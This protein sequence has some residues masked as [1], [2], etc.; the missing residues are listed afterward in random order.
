MAWR[1]LPHLPLFFSSFILYPAQPRRQGAG[2]AAISAAFVK[3][4]VFLPR[5]GVRFA[6]AGGR[7]GGFFGSV[8]AVW[9]LRQGGGGTYNKCIAAAGAPGHFGTREGDHHGT[10]L[11]FQR[12]AF[13]AAAA[14]FAKGPGRVARLPRLRPE[15]HGDEPPQQ[16]V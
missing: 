9:P 16:V 1:Y 2:M 4:F 10:C 8:T 6:C 7:W 13:D 5:T 3:Y 14:R 15:R 11:Q 12:G